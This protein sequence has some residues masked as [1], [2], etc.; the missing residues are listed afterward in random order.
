MTFVALGAF[1]SIVIL[2]AAYGYRVSAKTA[3]DYM[4]GGDGASGAHADD[5]PAAGEQ[6]AHGRPRV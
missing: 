2:M 5:P 6:A 4:L 1:G 3:E